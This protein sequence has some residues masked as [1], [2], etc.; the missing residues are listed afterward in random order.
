MR[1]EEHRE[2][3]SDDLASIQTTVVDVDRSEVVRDELNEVA[4]ALLLR[5]INDIRNLH[6]E[7]GGNVDNP[8]PGS[9]NQGMRSCL[10]KQVSVSERNS[11]F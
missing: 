5:R 4:K 2:E 7:H 3:N 10:L 9:V 11:H 1:S 8:A 6:S